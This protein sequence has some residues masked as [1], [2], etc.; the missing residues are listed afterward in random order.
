MGNPTRS[1]ILRGFGKL[2]CPNETALIAMEQEHPVRVGRRLAAI[3]AADVAGYSRLMGLDEVG[4]VRKRRRPFRR[5]PLD[6]DGRYEPLISP[7]SR[8]SRR[9]APGGPATHGRP[10]NAGLPIRNFQ[11]RRMARD[12][13]RKGRA[14][15]SGPEPR[16]TQR[17]HAVRLRAS[18][19]ANQRSWPPRRRLQLSSSF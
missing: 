9:L 13:L 19:R 4:T 17:R 15:N 1:C 18:G 7:Q 8:I 2:G 5:P 10:R 16:R 3:V 6:V 12:L 14:H 11:N